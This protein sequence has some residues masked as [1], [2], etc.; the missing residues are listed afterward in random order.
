MNPLKDFIL[1]SFFSDYERENDFPFTDK[2]LKD[3]HISHSP[4]ASLT[5]S[6]V[7]CDDAFFHS[8]SDEHLESRAAKTRKKSQIQNIIKNTKN[9]DRFLYILGVERD[10]NKRVIG[11][12]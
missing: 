6:L 3:T 2:A 4:I 9:K 7:C 10:Q 8:A 5:H 12:L 1:F 11:G